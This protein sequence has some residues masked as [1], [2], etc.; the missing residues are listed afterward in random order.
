MKQDIT[1]TLEN[2]AK[3]FALHWGMDLLY[4]SVDSDKEFRKPVPDFI[5]QS[6]AL[7]HC[8]LELKPLSS[9]SNEDAKDLIKLRFRLDGGDID[10][11]ID[12]NILVHKKNNRPNAVSVEAI[13]IHKLWDDFVEK[14]F[15]GEDT[16]A[17]YALIDFL[18]SRGYAVPWMGLSVNEM[19][20]Y[21]WIKLKIE[22]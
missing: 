1:N 6:E 16:R 5:C 18:R 9:L 4:R 15:I 3:F 11:V 17:I 2:K 20:K 8:S 14:L 13:I 12:V 10:N 22:I 7:E 19:V 21:G